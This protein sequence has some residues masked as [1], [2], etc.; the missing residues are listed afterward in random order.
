MREE[1]KKLLSVVVLCQQ[2]KNDSNYR[3]VPL[4]HGLSTTTTPYQ[5]IA[6]RQIYVKY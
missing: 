1:E 6:F 3:K 2:S 4:L 5:D